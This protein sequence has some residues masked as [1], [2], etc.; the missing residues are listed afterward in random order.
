MLPFFARQRSVRRSIRSF[1]LAEVDVLTPRQMLAGGGGDGS[2][3]GGDV[4]AGQGETG[5][6][7]ELDGLREHLEGLVEAEFG[8][9][10]VNPDPDKHN[11]AMD[12]I[13]DVIDQ[14]EE[15]HDVLTETP[16]PVFGTPM[17]PSTLMCMGP[18]CH[19]CQAVVDT[20][21]DRDPLDRW[22][23]RETGVNTQPGESHHWN[24][25]VLKD[26]D[27]DKTVIDFWKRPDKPWWPNQDEHPYTPNYERELE[28]PGELSDDDMVP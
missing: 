28:R 14:M 6:K 12:E 13:D 20:V 3:A 16:H 11:D 25:I 18:V 8:P 9:N 26:S 22:D 17:E 10:G 4:D 5:D 15:A 23:V 24:V 21:N 27:Q 1:A 7:P 19:Q 2:D